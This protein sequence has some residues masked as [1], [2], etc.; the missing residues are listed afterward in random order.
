MSNKLMVLLFEFLVVFYILQA[1]GPVFDDVFSNWTGIL[2]P[3][4]AIIRF[5]VPS[6]DKVLVTF[7]ES[8]FLIGFANK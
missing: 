8:L 5:F 7:I 2:A 3:F 1:F 4:G 6:P